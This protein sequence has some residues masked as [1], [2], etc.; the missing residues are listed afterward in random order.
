MQP[1]R[2]E[3]AQMC[4]QSWI[5][6]VG[7]RETECDIVE[8]EAEELSQQLPVI[9]GGISRVVVDRE[10]AQFLGHVGDHATL[11]CGFRIVGAMD[12]GEV[13]LHDRVRGGEETAEAGLAGAVRGNAEALRQPVDPQI[14]VS[15]LA[16]R[17]TGDDQVDPRRSRRPARTS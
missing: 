17:I 12:I 6:A 1:L 10:E 7:L 16:L 9:I 13:G 14:I 8:L 2:L 4:H 11:G 5:A 15:L 3:P